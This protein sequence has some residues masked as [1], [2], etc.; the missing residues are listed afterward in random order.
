MPQGTGEQ[1]PSGDEIERRLRELQAEIEGRG[2]AHEPS[3]AV[4]KAAVENQQAPRQREAA[5]A[6]ERP[7]DQAKAPERPRDQAKAP[8]RPGEQAREPGRKRPS[9]RLSWAVA[10]VVIAA[11]GGLYSWKHVSGT[12]AGSPD[13]TRA[14]TNGAIPPTSAQPATTAPVTPIDTQPVTN[15]AIPPPSTTGPGADPFAGTPADQWADSAA[16][17]TVPAAGPQGPFTAAQVAAAYETT[18]NLLI[19]ANLNPQTLRGGAPTTFANLLTPQQRQDFIAGLNKTGVDKQGYPLSTRYLVVSFA[20]GTTTLIGS[21]TKV[22][23]TMSAR[24][25]TDQGRTVLDIDVSY[26][27]VYPVE[28]PGDPANWMRIVAQTSGYVEFIDLQGPGTTDLQPFYAVGGSVAGGRCDVL[29]GFIHP[30]YPGG[31]P[32]KVQPTGTPVNPYSTQVPSAAKTCEL[33]TGT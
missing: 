12:T 30:E 25:G 15:G 2:R 1:S 21:V 7:R 13:D 33:T 16:G 28:P 18:R 24:T 22:Q 5:K 29:D 26:R 17:I 31:P 14:V 11:I 9:Q 10:I 20:P 32:D 3:A 23:G 6:P 19:A 8:E 27:F 4:R